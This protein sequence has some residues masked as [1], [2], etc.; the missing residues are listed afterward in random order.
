MSERITFWRC[1]HCLGTG[2]IFAVYA[3]APEVCAKCAGTGNAL[4]DGEA[5]RHRQRLSEFDSESLH[6]EA[7]K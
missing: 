1:G 5:E 6:H 4:V 7:E 3:I 2:R